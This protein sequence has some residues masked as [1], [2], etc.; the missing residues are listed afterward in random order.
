MA[1]VIKVLTDYDLGNMIT[2]M[3]FYTEPLVRHPDFRLFACMNPATDVGK[4]NLPLG[5]RNRWEQERTRPGV[6]LKCL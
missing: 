2:L 5:I 6:G 3:L 4:R 1:L